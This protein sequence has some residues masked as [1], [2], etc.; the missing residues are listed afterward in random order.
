MDISIDSSGSF[1]GLEKF[2]RK[3]MNT[4]NLRPILDAAGQEG[5]NALS[6]ATPV[7]T[8]RAAGAW[9]YQVHKTKYGWELVWNNSDRENGFPVVVMR[10]YG[11]G[12]GTGGYI[13]GVDFIN[14]ALKPVFAKIADKT[15]K[16]V[17]SV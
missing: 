10:Q 15:W 5:V 3:A 7:D 14:P 13:Q 11:H 12:T 9:S 16:A 6:A 2:L 8:G 1:Q 4:T 17:T